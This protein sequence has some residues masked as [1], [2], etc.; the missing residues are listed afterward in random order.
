MELKGKTVLITGSTD[1]IG[2]ETAFEAARLG[3]GVIVHGRYQEKVD[4]S[5]KEISEKTGNEKVYKLTANFNSLHEVTKAAEKL[6]DDFQQIDVL[7]NNAAEFL[8][9]RTLT[10]NELETQFQVNYL[11]HFLLTEKLLPLI[12]GVEGARI[13]NV[14]SMIHSNSIDFDNL[15]GEKEYTG[16]GA[17]ALTKLL[18]ILHANDLAERLKDDPVIVH[19]LHPGVIETKLLNAAWSGGAPVSVGAE[20]LLYCALS[21]ALE[22]QSGLYIENRR[23]MMS[24]PVSYDRPI[25]ERLRELSFELLKTFI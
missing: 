18:N 11:S 3:A 9:Q 2:K 24:N 8:H 21:E 22:H 6:S 4:A 17:Y 14:S 25:Q 12:K 13:L 10:E 7:F 23:P 1:G 5:V 19:S 20:N 16:N 15:Q